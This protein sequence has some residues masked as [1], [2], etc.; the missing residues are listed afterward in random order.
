[1][2]GQNRFLFSKGR[3]ESFG[4]GGDGYVFGEGVGVVFFKLFF[5]VKVDGDYIYGLI[6]GMVVNYDGKIN[7]YFVLNLNV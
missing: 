7:G 6:K 4:E 2:F 1:M 5:K 3:C